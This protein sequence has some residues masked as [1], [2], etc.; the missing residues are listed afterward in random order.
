MQMKFKYL[1]AEYV[2]LCGMFQGLL[3]FNR[4]PS[5]PRQTTDVKTVLYMERIS[6]AKL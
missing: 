5:G 3:T 6:R 4:I 2:V 1:T